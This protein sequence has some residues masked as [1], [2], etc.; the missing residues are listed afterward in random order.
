MT[1]NLLAFIGVALTAY[2]VPGPDWVFIAKG[3][4]SSRRQGFMAAAGIQTGILV[5]GTIALVGISA[6]IAANPEA[7]K[8]IQIIGAVYLAFLGIKSIIASFNGREPIKGKRTNSASENRIF[9]QAFAANLLNPKVVLFF[10]AILPQFV[11]QETNLPVQIAILTLIDVAV[12]IIWWTVLIVAISATT[13]AI[14]SATF[15]L[16]MNRI[17][18]LALLA[19]SLLLILTEVI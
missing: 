11:D 5:H 1:T 12:G 18:G 6:L 14:H 13:N 17:T 10:V 7:L 9:A 4:A 3:A 19:I 2:V 8:V 15:N 16:W